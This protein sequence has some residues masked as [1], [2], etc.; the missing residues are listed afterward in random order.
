[1]PNNTAVREK[2]K[3]YLE[4]FKKNATA[5]AH[6]DTF[7]HALNDLVEKPTRF[8]SGTTRGSTSP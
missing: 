2:L 1:M 7:L 8:T 4:E 5:G 6:Y 3:T